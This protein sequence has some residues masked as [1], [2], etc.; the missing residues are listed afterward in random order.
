V[1]AAAHGRTAAD[2]WSQAGRLGFR[3][4][5]IVVALL[6]LAW[7]TGNIRQVPPDGRAVVLRFGEPDRIRNPGLLLAWPEPIER[8]IF[9][10]SAERQI[11]H[12]IER[13]RLADGGEQAGLRLQTDADVRSNRGFLLTGDLGVA[14]L[15][16]TVTYRIVEPSAS[17]LSCAAIVA[18][19][20][21]TSSTLLQRIGSV[22]AVDTLGGTRLILPGPE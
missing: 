14:H 6:L 13:F 21:N 17:R 12:V 20:P 11:D 8:V 15:D 4:A 1:I 9:V 5:Q 16:A 2:P 19:R 18:S 7:A 22:T 3:A 10:P